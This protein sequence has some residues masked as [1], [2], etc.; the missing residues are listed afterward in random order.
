MLAPNH[1][2]GTDGDRRAGSL[3]PWVFLP[4]ALHLIAW[5]LGADILRLLAV[6]PDDAAYY[7]QIARNAAHG[8]GFT[9]DGIHATN[10]YQPLWQWLLVPVYAGVR[11]SPEGM[12][13]LV[14]A[15]QAAL[16][17]GALAWLFRTL[18]GRVNGLVLLPGAIIYGYLGLVMGVDGMETALL[19]AGLALLVAHAL[20]AGVFRTPAGPPQW[21]WGFLLGG[22][23]LARLDA[24]FLG[25][26]VSAF[27][28]LQAALD[29]PR[30]SDHMRR[31]ARVV[32]GASVV[33]LP[34]LLGNWLKF[35]DAMPISARL[36]SCFPHLSPDGLAA[37]PRS[38]QVLVLV[39]ATWLAATAIMIWRWRRRQAPPPADFDVAVAVLAGY[40]V[41]HSLHVTLFLK[42][43][44]FA[45]HF[46]GNWTFASLAFLALAQRLLPRLPGLCRR[47]TAYWP[48]IALLVLFAGWRVEHRQA[49]T[50]SNWHTATWEAARWARAS[51]T[52]DAVF[53]MKDAGM[54]GY[55]AERRTINLDG[56]VNDRSFQDTLRKRQLSAYLARNGVAYLVQHAFPD[57]P[58]V[59]AGRYTDFRM[60]YQSHLHGAWSDT[61]VLHRDDEVFRSRSYGAGADSTVLAVWRL[62]PR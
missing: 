27:M 28:V 33:V 49:R 9:F 14:L 52:S 54:F 22:V 43:A 53:A 38:H 48:A 37:V 40:V 39:A 47:P 36:K 23:M 13:R 16:L 61:L 41:L 26:A 17:A 62:T 20:A 35:G 15:L 59:S 42:W 45:W 34:Y 4:Y 58:E 6:V 30:R 51:T 3:A 5:A 7:L 2:V 8:V 55:F 57:N 50:T 60:A 18:R 24:V 25:V 10:G 29:P 56:V 44:V 1:P 46:A 31:L 19:A 11:G 32:G 21:L 12:F